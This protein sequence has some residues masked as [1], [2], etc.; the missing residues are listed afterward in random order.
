MS[1][2]INDNMILTKSPNSTLHGDLNP[3]TL[4]R[5]TTMDIFIV[6]QEIVTRLIIAC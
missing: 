6:Y 2:A 3:I 1:K 4:L 5:N